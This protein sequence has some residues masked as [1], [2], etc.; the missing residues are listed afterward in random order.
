MYQA[1]E[2]VEIAQPFSLFMYNVIISKLLFYT[3]SSYN[4]EFLALRGSCFLIYKGHGICGA[5]RIDYNP[6]YRKC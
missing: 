3:L 5:L 4:L 1:K 2:E 6:S